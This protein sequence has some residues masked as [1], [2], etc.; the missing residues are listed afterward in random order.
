MLTRLRRALGDTSTRLSPGMLALRAAGLFVMALAVALAVLAAVVLDGQFGV[1]RDN[2]QY[3]NLGG[4][5]VL[6][7]FT[8]V[9]LVEDLIFQARGWFPNSPAAVAATRASLVQHAS[10]FVTAHRAMYAMVQGT[11]I[12]KLYSDAENFPLEPTY[13]NPPEAAGTAFGSFV[14]VNLFQAGLA[15]ANEFNVIAAAPL[16]NMTDDNWAPLLFV[17]TNCLPGGIAHETIHSTSLET[18]YANSVQTKLNV[19]NTAVYVYVS[20]SAVLL[21]VGLAVF[22]PILVSIE[23]SKDEIVKSFVSLPPRVKLALQQ[24]AENRVTD[25]RR[26]FSD[27]DDEDDDD[28]ETSADGEGEGG[29]AD[30]GGGGGDGGRGASRADRDGGGGYADED[31]DWDAVIRLTR[32]EAAAAERGLAS[33]ASM[34]AGRAAGGR[35][36]AAAAPAAAGDGGDGCCA[37]ACRCSRAPGGRPGSA[38]AAGAGAGARK[39]KKSSRSALLL[40]AK[41]L[42]PLFAL[43]AFFSAIFIQSQ[44]TLTSVLAL[45]SGQVSAA[46]RTACTR[47]TMMDLT[48]AVMVHSDRTFFLVELSATLDTIDCVRYHEQLLMFGIKNEEPRGDYAL[49]TPVTE[50]GSYALLTAAQNAF[51]ISAQIVDACPVAVGAPAAYRAVTAA[52]CAAWGGGVMARGLST[53]TAE[54]VARARRVMDRRER[55][56]V[57]WG[58]LDGWVIPVPLYPYANDT[59]GDPGTPPG[60]DCWTY[61]VGGAFAGLVVSPGPTL[62]ELGDVHADWNATAYGAVPWSMADDINSADMAWLRDA[63]RLFITPVMDVIQDVYDAQGKH[64]ID[65]YRA[66]LRSFVSVFVSVFIAFMLAVFLPLVH[67][68]HNELQKKR[69]MLLFLPPQVIRSVEAIRKLIEAILAATDPSSL[70]RVTAG[71]LRANATLR[72]AAVEEAEGGGGGGDGAHHLRAPG[73]APELG[74]TGETGPLSRCRN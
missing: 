32:K 24:Q 30:G 16:A 6:G 9:S 63:D 68:L 45:S 20:I 36:G 62:T 5:R 57:A 22:T 15:I 53:A 42:G 69:A 44:T 8:S 17:L 4:R 23:N 52:E 10:D 48:R 25:L 28:E 7:F 41:F 40:F 29:A 55:A 74:T 64:V 35:G 59:C 49:T 66:F 71:A 46:Y 61:P 31:V 3:T 38:R 21:L 12:A 11:P 58:R 65:E 2:L 73:D 51:L 67:S 26:N 39:Y 14:R 70:S 60:T 13:Y 27:E 19:Y 47:E 33:S 72:S 43:F 50:T 1:Y 37:R 34:H 56:R 18:G 54:F